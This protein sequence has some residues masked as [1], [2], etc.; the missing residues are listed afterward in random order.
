MIPFARVLKYGN[1][2]DTTTLLDIDFSKQSVGSTNVQDWT[3]HSVFSVV[4]GAGGVVQYDSVLDSNVMVLGGNTRY[5]TAMNNYLNLVGIN[6]EINFVFKS[7]STIPQCPWCTGDYN[8]GRIPGINFSVN[9]VSANYLQWFIDSGGDFNRIIVGGPNPQVWEDVTFR[10]TSTEM[11]VI[12][13]RLG[14]TQNFPRYSYGAGTNFSL[15][16]SYSGGTPNYFTGSV[17][18]LHIKRI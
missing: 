2:L 15:F 18:K 10:C 4:A 12:N 5:N 17:Q 14:T 6:F 11:I 9:A 8:G 13:N 7:T 16:G 3:N 1:V